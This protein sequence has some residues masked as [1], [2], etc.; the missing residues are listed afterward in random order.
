V[1]E[2]AAWR[3]KDGEPV[4]SEFADV[5]PIP[6]ARLLQLLGPQYFGVATSEDELTF[7][8]GTKRIDA[9]SLRVRLTY[10]NVGDHRSTT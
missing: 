4:E 1:V 9:L 2:I 3:C 8:E 7:R 5:D 10:L 6:L